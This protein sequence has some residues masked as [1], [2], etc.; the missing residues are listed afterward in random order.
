MEENMKTVTRSKKS[1][2]KS[3]KMITAIVVLLL[4]LIAGLLGY[5]FFGKGPDDAV[6]L[7]NSVK[8]ELGQLENKSN[9]EIEAELNRIIDE[10]SMAISINLNP[11]FAEGTKEGTLRIENSPANHYA[12]EVVI[13]LDETGEELYRSGLLLPNYHIQNDVLAVDLPEGEYEC[14]AL[15]TAYDTDK[16]TTVGNATAKI[17]ISVLS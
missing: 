11:V 12:Q 13:T 7:E 4:L 2:A 15:F 14:T 1:K 3:R 6:V 9:E 16:L 8:A 17:R 5:H 10:G